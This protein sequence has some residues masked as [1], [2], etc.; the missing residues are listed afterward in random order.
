MSN[1]QK[2]PVLSSFYLVRNSIVC[3]HRLK[4]IAY[5]KKQEISVRC[6]KI[7]GVQNILHADTSAIACSFDFIGL[8]DQVNV[9][10]GR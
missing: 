10:I 6:A 5:S 1:T 4:D 7:S 8:C 3:V 2:I 9:C